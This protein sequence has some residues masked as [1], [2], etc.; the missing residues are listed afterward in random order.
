[1]DKE[2][3]KE[4]FLGKIERGANFVPLSWE[5][6]LDWDTL[7]KWHLEN[8]LIN[9]GALVYRIYK[10]YRGERNEE[11]KDSFFADAVQ[12][13][14][15]RTYLSFYMVRAVIS[16]Y[17]IIENT[18]RKVVQNYNKTQDLMLTGELS[19]LSVPTVKS[20]LVAEKIL[21]E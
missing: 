4:Y 18:K 14:S 21:K 8:G 13:T 5:L 11:G 3:M 1:M 20:I 7:V 19:H 9:E 17:M 10:Q 12:K 16:E 15:V 6:G 2:S